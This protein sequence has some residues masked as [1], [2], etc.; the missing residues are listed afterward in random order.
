MSDYLMAGQLS[1][2][3]R[4]Q[5]QARVWEPAGGRLL[6]ELGRG[7]G[8]RVVDVGCGCLGW[9]R[10]LSRWVGGNGEVVGTD[11]A[12]PLLDAAQ[13]FVRS[14]RLDNVRLVEDD[15]FASNLPSES[16]D[17]V[18]A[19]F[20]IAPLG[21][22]DEQLA[23]YRRLTARGGRLVLEDPDSA[24]WHCNPPA[25]SVARLIE[26]ILTAFRDAG[27]DFDAGRREADLLRAQGLD[28]AVRAEVLALPP[29]HAYLHL[30]LQFSASLESRLLSKM[31]KEE[32][33]RLRTDASSEL[34][35][36]GRWGTTFTLLQTW[37]TLP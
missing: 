19:R 21:R 8:R 16:F 2:L 7:D 27:G 23:A 15:L 36:P 26:L 10:L 12:G 3:D 29:G 37:A 30:P 28:P 20:Q 34:T 6:A 32:L 25:P 31:A 13:D 22:A 5:L 1:E 35:A 18:H 14:E 24:S 33:E 11:I 4:L 17:L 9:L